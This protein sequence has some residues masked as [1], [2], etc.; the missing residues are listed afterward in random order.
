[1]FATKETK[2][3]IKR[4]VSS[5]KKPASQGSTDSIRQTK[6]LLASTH[7]LQRNMGNSYLQS[8]AEGRQSLVGVPTIQT[9]EDEEIKIQPKLTIGPVNDV[10]EQEADR[11]AEQVM[12]MSEKSRVGIRSETV[13]QLD[14]AMITP[15]QISVRHD[16]TVARYALPFVDVGD[17]EPFEVGQEESRPEEET[18]IQRKALSEFEIQRSTIDGSQTATTKVEQ[19]IE[20]IM[21]YGGEPLSSG[22]R[23]F[24]DVR[25]GHDFSTVRIHTD[26]L[27]G[28]VSRQLNARAFTFGNHIFFT[29][30]EFRPAE[31]SGRRLLAHELTH[32]IQQGA[33]KNSLREKKVQRS[34]MDTLS[35]C[36]IYFR[37][38]T[39]RNVE[40]YN[41]AGLAHRTYRVMGHR[42]AFSHLFSLPGACIGCSDS[43]DSGWV[44]Y[45]VWEYNLHF[46]DSGSRRVAPTRCLRTGVCQTI[47]TSSTGRDFH[48]VAGITDSQGNDPTD[49]YS[50]NGKRPVYGP[51]TGPSFRPPPREH[52]TLSN[53]NETP[54]YDAAHNPIYKV[55]TN[56][57]EKCYCVPCL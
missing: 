18:E 56:I 12:R 36:P 19:S 33:S 34:E 13:K 6:N 49:V 41:C 17:S 28:K 9:K 39:A 4:L 54:M 50:K 20:G 5:G 45:W 57:S 14:R 10:Y 22:M 44:K 25:F 32:V 47:P 30:G 7:L 51:G 27:A 46:E 53:R 31:F 21:R 3:Q 35:L 15:S 29:P 24:M 48:M 52:S 40:R 2:Q 37:Y 23:D 26:E 42:S 1:M 55:R 11:V 43:C 8:V 38:D 16:Q